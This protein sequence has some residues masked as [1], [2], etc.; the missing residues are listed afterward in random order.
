M[1]GQSWETAKKETMPIGATKTGGSG[2]WAFATGFG[3]RDKV[4]VRCSG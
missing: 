4:F 2:C 3:L 1:V